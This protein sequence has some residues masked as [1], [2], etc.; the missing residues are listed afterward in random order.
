MPSAVYVSV[1]VIATAGLIYELIAAAAASYLLG[2]SLTQFSTVIGSYLFAMGIGSYLSRYLRRNLAAWFVQGQILVGLAGGWSAALLFLAFVHTQYFR[3]IL[4]GLVGAI[5]VLVGLEIPLLLRLLRQRLALRE[6]VAHVLSL[7]YLGALAASILFPLFLVP[8][9]GLIRTA[10]AF[11]LANVAVGLWSTWIFR[12][13]IVVARFLRAV[14]VAAMLIL[15]GG[16][17]AA[18]QLTA[19][20]EVRLYADEVILAR[21]SPYQRIVLTRAGDD[22]RLFLNGHLQFSS[23]DEYRYHEALI[24]PALAAHP[25]PRRVLVLGGGDGLGLR[26]ILKYPAVRSVTLVDL[27]PEMTRL[28]STH[29]FLRGLNEGAFADRRV[30]VVNDDAF[31]WLDRQTD[32]FDVVIVDLPDPHSFSLGKLYSRSFYRL[33]RSRL[34]PG[35]L[36]TVQATSPLFARRSFW[37]IVETIGSAGLLPHPYHVHVPSFGAW[38]FVL[39]SQT[40]YQPPRRYPEGL[41]FLTVRGTPALFD[42]PPDMARVP[43]EVNR[44]DNQV[45]VQ[46]YAEEWRRVFPSSY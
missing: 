36:A 25:D 24:H 34:A 23:R 11:G 29:A 18:E 9:L 21:S 19:W 15:G 44:L 22:V 5:G 32:V 16:L 27:D 40:P 20:A 30:R 4:Y 12:Q 38:G 3:A 45:L 35:G 10:F 37:C 14:A 31:V 41:R 6:L 7:D 26:E 8:R 46:Y 39:A 33:V 28:F 43:V 1:V 42:F 17:I 2:D 13:E